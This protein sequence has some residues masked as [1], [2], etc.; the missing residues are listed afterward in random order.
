[1]H[2][3]GQDAHKIKGR[4]TCVV[5]MFIKWKKASMAGIRL[6]HTIACCGENMYINA[7][8]NG[9][10]TKAP[11]AACIYFQWNYAY[12]L[13]FALWRHPSPAN[14]YWQLQSTQFRW[15]FSQFSIDMKVQ[16]K[17]VCI[18]IIYGM[19]SKKKIAYADLHTR[20]RNK[21]RNGGSE[22][23]VQSDVG[24]HRSTNSTAVQ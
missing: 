17:C 2:V 4:C 14:A 21:E 1:M 7:D 22:R 10:A 5:K 19:N 15:A 3:C 20:Q 9:Q 24:P 11:P 12:R 8:T 6:N 23:K 18:H 13:L 16:F